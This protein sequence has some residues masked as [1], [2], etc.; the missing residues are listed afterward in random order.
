MRRGAR[1]RSQTLAHGRHSASMTTDPDLIPQ[2]SRHGEACCHSDVRERAPSTL[3]AAEF[4][5]HEPFVEHR[6]FQERVVVQHDDEAPRAVTPY[7]R[8]EERDQRGGAVDAPRPAHSHVAA[9]SLHRLPER[10]GA[11]EENALQLSAHDVGH[12]GGGGGGGMLGAAPLLLRRW[13][14]QQA[15]RPT[16]GRDRALPGRFRPQYFVT[17]TDVT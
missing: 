6:V 15:E 11:G 12:G 7:A 10:F 4:V 14:S 16:V 1:N 9:A 5:S 3:L 13:R 17:G 8:A 2:L